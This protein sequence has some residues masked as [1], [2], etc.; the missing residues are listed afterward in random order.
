MPGGFDREL[1]MFVADADLLETMVGI[2]D[3]EG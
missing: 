1:T 3:R 2:T